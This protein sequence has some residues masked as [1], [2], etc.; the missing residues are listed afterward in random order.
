MLV[1]Q[2]F[3]KKRLVTITTNRL[4]SMEVDKNSLVVIASVI[5]IIVVRVM[6]SIPRIRR[7]VRGG[8]S[9]VSIDIF[10]YICLISALELVRLAWSRK[11]S[12]TRALRMDAIS[13]RISFHN[14]RLIRY[15]ARLVGAVI[16]TR[17]AGV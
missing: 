1:E 10:F 15:T 7:F 12:G 3:G 13:R 8:F 4:Y 16:I 11:M 9:H 17:S 2:L 5:L 14:T 6:A